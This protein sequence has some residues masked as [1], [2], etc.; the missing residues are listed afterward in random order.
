[1][2]I[3]ASLALFVALATPNAFCASDAA[4]QIKSV[5]NTQVEA[6]NRGDIPAFV[7]TYAPDCT[8]VGKKVVRG[9][10]QL[11]ARYERTY[12]TREAMGHLTFS[13]VEVHLLAEDVAFVTGEWHVE[14][15]VTGGNAIGGLFSLVFRRQGKEWKIALDHT[16]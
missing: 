5:L 6:W 1:M 4:S 8:F 7:S 14:R 12:P 10:A 16:S 9:R 15:S 11:L 3:V 13:A 2:K